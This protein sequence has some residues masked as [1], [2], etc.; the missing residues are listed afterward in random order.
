[1]CGWVRD[2]SDLYQN[3]RLTEF[4]SRRKMGRM[5]QKC[6]NAVGRR[7]FGNGIIRATSRQTRATAKYLKAPLAFN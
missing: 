3:R 5:L 1:M 6:L 4:A 7:Q 2:F